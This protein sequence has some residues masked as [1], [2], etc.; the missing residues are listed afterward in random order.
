M[1][2]I[3]NTWL[4]LSAALCI[5]ALVCAASA[6]TSPLLG[7]YADLGYVPGEVLVKFKASADETAKEAAHTSAK[8]LAIKTNARGRF[9]KVTLQKGV[10]T[11]SSIKA[12]LKNNT[13]EWA[14]PNYIVYADATPTD[15]LYLRQ[16]NF[17]NPVY[18]GHY[19]WIKDIILC[20]LSSVLCKI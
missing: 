1:P 10:D 5:L 2:H 14:E 11:V 4:L 12:Y 6:A 18:K 15:P 16:W 17:Q 20:P 8:A 13:V 3:R 9:T 7:K 19:L